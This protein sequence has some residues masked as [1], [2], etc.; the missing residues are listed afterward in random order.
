[1]WREVCA[2]I[3]GVNMCI[4]TRGT[5]LWVHFV[6]LG[7]SEE[8]SCES[9]RLFRDPFCVLLGQGI[10]TEYRLRHYFTQYI[11]LRIYIITY[12][13]VLEGECSYVY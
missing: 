10:K 6:I 4:W 3:C 1:M 12:I 7:I 5:G 2:E 9:N 11:L 13:I 8:V